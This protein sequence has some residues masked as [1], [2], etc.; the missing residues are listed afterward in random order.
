LR[1]DDI[2]ILA[3][4]FDRT[5]APAI[6]VAPKEA[7]LDAEKLSA[8]GLMITG[9]SLRIPLIACAGARAAWVSRPILIGGSVS[10]DTVCEAFQVADGAVLSSVPLRRGLPRWDADKTRRFM[11]KVRGSPFCTG[12]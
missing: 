2:A 7:A 4:I 8:D 9:G 5:S 12:E 6:E 11:D 3:D 1:R 10:E